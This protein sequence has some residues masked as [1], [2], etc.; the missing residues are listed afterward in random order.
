[1]PEP[2]EGTP[3]PV[4]DIF[5]AE[6]N[7]PEPDEEIEAEPIAPEPV[8]PAAPVVP[9]VEPTASPTPSPSPAPAAVIP[10]PEPTAP[11]VAPDSALRQQLSEQAAEIAR[12]KGV[13]TQWEAQKKT[14]P[15]PGPVAGAFADDAELADFMTDAGKANAVFAKMEERAVQNAVAIMSASVSQHLSI[16][17]MVRDAEKDFMS[18]NKDLAPFKPLLGQFSAKVQSEHP[19]WGGDEDSIKKLF[20][21]TGKRT[22]AFLQLTGQPAGQAPSGATPS[23]TP[24]FAPGTGTRKAP[25]SATPSKQLLAEVFSDD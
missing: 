25:P 5:G 20:E 4:G 7:S 16:H 24:G 14:A 18:E 17:L 12:L 22:R 8:A 1:M 10:S 23:A 3:V 13:E 19:E 6:D 21:E 15:A 2:T 9:V 11:I